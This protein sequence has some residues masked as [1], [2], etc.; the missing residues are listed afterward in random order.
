MSRESNEKN[1]AIQDGR[2]ND[3]RPPERDTSDKAASE[4]Y[5]NYNKDYTTGWNEETIIRVP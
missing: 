5:D 4:K 3:Y 2:N 1:E